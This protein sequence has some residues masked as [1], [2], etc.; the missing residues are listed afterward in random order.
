MYIHIITLVSLLFPEHVKQ[1]PTSGPF[2]ILFCLKCSSSWNSHD[3]LHSSL[4]SISPHQRYVSWSVLFIDLFFIPFFILVRK[5]HSPYYSDIIHYLF[6]YSLR[7]SSSRMQT[8]LKA[9]TLFCSP[10]YPQCLK[11]NWAHER[12]SINKH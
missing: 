3:H 10:L 6:I 12:C 1:A 5:P 7:A 4:C 2:H 8:P 9:G 11:H